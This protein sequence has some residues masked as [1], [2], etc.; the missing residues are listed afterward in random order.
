MKNSLLTITISA[1]LL[2]AQSA[3]AFEQQN[4]ENDPLFSSD[5]NTSLLMTKTS[6][7]APHT[8]MIG[9]SENGSGSVTLMTDNNFASSQ[10]VLSI[11]YLSNR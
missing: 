7:V 2:V 5:T 9:N 4:S 6:Y 11:D 10:D 1:L 8:H 3:M